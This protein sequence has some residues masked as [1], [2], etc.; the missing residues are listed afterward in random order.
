MKV[1]GQSRSIAG[2]LSCSNSIKFGNAPRIVADGPRFHRDLK[3][4][5]RLA[6]TTVRNSIEA[7]ENKS[8]LAHVHSSETKNLAN[9]PRWEMA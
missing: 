7:S 5:R 3:T 2:A 8:C 6:Q 4:R 9:R 1:R